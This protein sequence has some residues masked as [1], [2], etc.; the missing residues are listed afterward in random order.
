MIVRLF[1][2]VLL[3]RS[4]LV[5]CVR[6]VVHVRLGMF[7][8]YLFRTGRGFGFCPLVHCIRWC[9]QGRIPE[10]AYFL[11]SH[12]VEILLN[13]SRCSS[14]LPRLVYKRGWGG[15]RQG[16]FFIILSFSNRVS[17]FLFSIRLF[18]FLIPYVES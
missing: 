1:A 6:Y 2:L 4:N 9:P 8:R 7:I 16:L 12:I 14:M 5:M 18:P 10:I 15:C 13:C 3:F 11:F 17:D